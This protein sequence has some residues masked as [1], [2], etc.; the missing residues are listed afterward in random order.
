MK[1]LGGIERR[2]N[3]YICNKNVPQPEITKVAL[4]HCNI[5]NDQH[6]HN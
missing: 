1:L 6:Q 2:I 3:R 4:V 5:V